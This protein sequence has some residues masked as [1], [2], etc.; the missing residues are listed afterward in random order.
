MKINFT[1]KSHGILDIAKEINESNN[2]QMK[3]LA[4]FVKEVA[5]NIIKSE[6]DSFLRN[7]AKEH[8]EVRNWLESH[9]FLEIE[10]EKTYHVGQKFIMDRQKY[11]LA[12]C[13]GGQVAL[14]SLLDGN[15]WQ[16]PI[17]VTDVNYI[18]EE[19]FLEMKAG[20][21]FKVKEE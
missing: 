19:E 18:S 17:S 16:D 21:T 7:W 15:R 8:D 5:T 14:I 9:G 6:Y 13:H 12:Q 11:I 10:K 20:T 3:W 2:C 4:K 1:K